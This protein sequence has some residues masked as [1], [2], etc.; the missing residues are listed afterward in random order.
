MQNEQRDE[1]TGL[2]NL[3]GAM[4]QIQH[5]A[6][7]DDGGFS[8]IVYLNV[9]NFKSF[10]QQY[11]FVGGNEFLRGVA[12]EI[13]NIFSDDEIARTGGDQFIILSK[14]LTPSV[15]SDKLEQLRTAAQKYQRSLTMRI[16][17]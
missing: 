11:G 10:N 7:D 14:K 3:N 1:L 6:S 17:A 5:H 8:V 9:M 12:K 4:S 13:Q 15:I 2:L 16:K